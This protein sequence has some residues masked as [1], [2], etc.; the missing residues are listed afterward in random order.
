MEERGRID[1]RQVIIMQ[2]ETA[3]RKDGKMARKG[4][5]KLVKYWIEWLNGWRLQS[6]TSPLAGSPL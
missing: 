4:K 1:E 2:R 3:V 5:A 6:A